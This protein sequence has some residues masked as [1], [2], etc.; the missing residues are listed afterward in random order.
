MKG[1]RYIQYIRPMRTRF[2][3]AVALFL[4]HGACYPLMPAAALKRSTDGSSWM[5]LCVGVAFWVTL[6]GAWAMVIAANSCRRAYARSRLKG[7]LRMGRRPGILSFF[8]TLPGTVADAAFAAALIAFVILYLTGKINSFVSYYLLAVL[9][10]SGNLH[11]MFNGRIYHT[12]IKTKRKSNPTKNSE[13][14]Q[15]Q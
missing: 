1:G 5:L 3:A 10:I 12:I 14:R 7:D 9:S 8:S 15:P 6:L 13:E 4:I 11:G 2:W